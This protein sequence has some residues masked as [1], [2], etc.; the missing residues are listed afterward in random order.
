MK[1][2]AR[3]M[4]LRKV[5]KIVTALKKTAKNKRD[6]QRFAKE[7][8]ISTS[9]LQKMVKRRGT[10]ALKR[11]IQTAK[12]VVSVRKSRLKHKVKVKDL[13]AKLGVSPRTVVRDTVGVPASLRRSKMARRRK[14]FVSADENWYSDES[15]N[16]GRFQRAMNL[17][18]R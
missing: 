10:D 2:K 3:C 11:R 15:L 17:Y 6:Y 13:A 16:A 4:D 18:C 14:R 12:R 5:A 9:T 8:K 7:L 1:P